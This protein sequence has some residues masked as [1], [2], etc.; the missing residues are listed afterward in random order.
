MII[1]LD[2]NGTIATDGKIKEGV[3]ERLAIL[4]EISEI[5]ILSADTFGTLNDIA[6]DL[7]VKGI[8]I[9]REKYGS[10][11]IAKLKILE[12][13]KKENP[14]KKIIAIGNGNNDELLLKNADLGICVIGDEGAWSK[15]ILSSDIVVKDIIDA[16]DLV[17]KENRMKATIRD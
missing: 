16:L 10:E 17:L 11:K 12:E 8:K 7:N 9:D 13:L 14:N 3:K 2:L 5:Y 4:K 15:T 6:N 1:L